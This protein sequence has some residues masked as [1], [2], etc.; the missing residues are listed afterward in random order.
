MPS[1]KLRRNLLALFAML[2]WVGLVLYPDPRVFTTSVGRLIR[3]PIDAQAVRGLA[4]TLPNDPHAIER[5]SMGYVRYASAW[6]VYHQ[7]WYFPT[8]KEVLRDRAGDCQAQALLMAS[9]MKAKGLP[10]TL[11]YSFDHVWVD[12]PGR[13]VTSTLTDPGTAFVSGGGKGWFASLPD[14]F[15]IRDIVDQ[16]VAFHWYPMP[17]DR[18]G[19]LLVGVMALFLAGG[20]LP[21]RLL[22]L[23]GRDRS[24]RPRDLETSRS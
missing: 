3:P 11:R 20:F 7:P 12:Y 23:P 8:V 2:L 17:A 16:R 9:L 10:F 21:S 15:P 22:R 6:D 14:K 18:K 1:R 24:P 4:A 13:Q 5:F 19:A